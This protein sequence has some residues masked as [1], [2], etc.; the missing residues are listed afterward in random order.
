MS[1]IPKIWNAIVIYQER[2]GLTWINSW[3]FA[4]ENF[5]FEIRY[6]SLGGEQI[7]K[8]IKY[9]LMNQP[10]VNTFKSK[11][12]GSYV[13][14]I[15]FHRGINRWKFTACLMQNAKHLTQNGALNQ[16]PPLPKKKKKKRVN[17][18]KFQV[19]H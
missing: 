19:I 5:Q 8:G 6:K 10:Y 9:Q 3:N 4:S 11:L 17:W 1:D 18:V 16:N 12:Y 15:C 7:V 2:I 13:L 14:I